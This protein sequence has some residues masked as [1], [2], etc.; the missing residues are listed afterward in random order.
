[1]AFPPDYFEEMDGEGTT[2]AEVAGM[3]QQQLGESFSGTGGQSGHPQ[4]HQG[5]D[6]QADRHPKHLQTGAE[7]MSGILKSYCHL[8]LPIGPRQRIA[9]E[10]HHIIIDSRGVSGAVEIDNVLPLSKGRA[11]NWAFRWTRRACHFIKAG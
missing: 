5:P 3:S 11:G 4:G 10:A 1:M 6:H 8:N 2:N 7:Y 9:I